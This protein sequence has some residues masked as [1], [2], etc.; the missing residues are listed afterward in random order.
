MQEKK[1]VG[2]RK[3][4]IAG[5][6]N[7]IGLELS[8]GICFPREEMIVGGKVKCMENTRECGVCT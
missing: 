8:L 2:R 5:N 7:W 6:P 3:E 1:N 4:T